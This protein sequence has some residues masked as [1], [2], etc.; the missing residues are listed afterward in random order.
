MLAN[1]SIHRSWQHQPS[2]VGII[3]LWLG[4]TWIYG[5]WNKATDHGFLSAESAHYIGAQLTGYLTTSPISFL[6]R[7]MVGHA[8]LIG[9]V[10]MISEFAIGIATL[11]GIALELAALGGFSMSIVLWLSASWS[12]QPYFLGSDSAYAILWLALFLLVRQKRKGSRRVFALFPSLPDRREALRVSAVAFTAVAAA[13]IG[14][15]V[16]NFGP[17]PEA[18]TVIIALSELPVGTN[19]NFT[20]VDGTPAIVFRSKVGVFAYTRRCT[21]QGCTISYDQSTHFLQCPCHGAA[22]DPNNYG[23]IMGGPN[24]IAQLPTISVV[25]KS[26]NV[27]QI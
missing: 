11:T 8:T 26:G 18:G 2:A 17:T 7:P 9:W 6:L 22:Y 13:F 27:Y 16:K 24:N 23:A 3:R 1:F 20:A 19:K 21:H 15:I 25:V 14:G 10:V 12:V 5:G 4:A